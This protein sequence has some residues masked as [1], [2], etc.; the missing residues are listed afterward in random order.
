MG[1][2]RFAVADAVLATGQSENASRTVS[3]KCFVT[4]PI[5]AKLY[6][7]IELNVGVTR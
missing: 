3:W 6:L 4:Y 1:P 7:Q 2:T 5:S